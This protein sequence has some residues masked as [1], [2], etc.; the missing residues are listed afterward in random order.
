MLSTSLHDIH[1]RPMIL[2]ALG[3][4]G[5]KGRR[6]MLLFT[7]GWI[8]RKVQAMASSSAALLIHALFVLRPQAYKGWRS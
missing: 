2:K 4:L 5:L 1:P 7:Q 3:T 6:E 8:M